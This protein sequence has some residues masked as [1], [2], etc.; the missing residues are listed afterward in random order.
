MSSENEF[1]SGKNVAMLSVG[2]RRLAASN[3]FFVI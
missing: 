2:A 1:L 3:S